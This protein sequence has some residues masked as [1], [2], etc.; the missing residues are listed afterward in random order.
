MAR[1]PCC[2]PPPHDK[3][4]VDQAEKEDAAQSTAH[5]WALQL[6]VSLRY[7]HT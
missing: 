4:H 5:A 3:V 6:R 1:L 7:G 2:E